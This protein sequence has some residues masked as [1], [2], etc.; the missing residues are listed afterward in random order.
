VCPSDG[1]VLPPKAGPLSAPAR[2]TSLAHRRLTQACVQLEHRH[3]A[4]ARRRATHLDPALGA[5]AIWCVVRPQS[6]SSFITPTVHPRCGVRRAHSSARW[7]RARD[8][9]SVTVPRGL[10]TV[11]SADP[12]CFGTIAAPPACPSF[13]LHSRNATNSKLREHRIVERN[14]PFEIVRCNRHM[15]TPSDAPY[16][17]R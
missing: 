1:P 10:A 7:C 8:H 3:G 9:P 11:R 13:I 2:W 4:L 12:Y 16:V 15:A 17:A 5:V 14:T 6:G